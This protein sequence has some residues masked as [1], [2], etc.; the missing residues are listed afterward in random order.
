[1]KLHLGCG[2][3][4]IE[5]FINVDIIEQDGVDVVDDVSKLLN[6]KNESADLIYACHVLEHFKRK[7]YF[8]VLK[9]WTEVLKTGGILRLS[10]PDFEKV[11]KVYY[12]E[13]HGLDELMGFLQ[14]GQTFGYNF[15]FMNFDYKTLQKDLKELNYK[16]IKLWDWRTTEH[17]N[18]DDY[19]QSYLPHMDKENGELMSLNIQAIKK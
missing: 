16:G 4:R 18:V 8:D 12:E 17:T 11:A 19:S 10:V 2:K 7:E 13:K 6:F 3:K 1:M 5:G 9:R 15:H 14:G